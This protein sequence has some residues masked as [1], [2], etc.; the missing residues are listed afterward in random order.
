MTEVT[1]TFAIRFKSC[2]TRQETAS[3]T[4]T[5]LSAIRYAQLENRLTNK[6]NEYI[7]N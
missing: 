1:S 7:Y 5:I 3:H 2:I 4:A 6:T